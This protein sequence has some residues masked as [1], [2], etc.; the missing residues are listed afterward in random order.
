MPGQNPRHR[1]LPGVPHS[2]STAL[3][4]FDS[5]DGQRRTYNVLEVARIYPRDTHTCILEFNHPRVVIVTGGEVEVRARI[6]EVTGPNP[7]TVV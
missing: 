6:A 5:P 2:M 7:P 1:F 4:D 3:L